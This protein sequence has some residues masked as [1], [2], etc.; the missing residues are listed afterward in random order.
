MIWT[1]ATRLCETETN[2]KVI[3]FVMGHAGIETT[4]NI[5][6]DATEKK[7]QESFEELSSKL[8]SIF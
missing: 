2:L 4:M 6:A 5:Y 7:K 3:Q 1:F 8:D